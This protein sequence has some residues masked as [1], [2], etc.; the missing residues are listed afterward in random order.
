VARS[1][2]I[3]KFADL[4]AITVVCGACGQLSAQ[5]AEPASAKPAP[6]AGVAT[7]TDAAA[8]PVA[9]TPATPS[10]DCPCTAATA[11]PSL[12]GGDL[13]ERAK[14]TGNWGGARDTLLENGYNFNISNTNF[15]QGVASGGLDRGFQ[16]G[17]RVDYLFD[18]DGKKAG[19]WD[20][21]FVNLHGETLYGKSINA[22]TGAFM[23]PNIA[24]S[25]PVPDE[26][27]TALTGV[28]FTQ[29]F[30]E[31]FAV[32]FGK[33]NTLD[34]FN[35]PFTGGARGTDGFMAGGILFPVVMARTIPYSTFGA[36]GVVLSEKEPIF[37]VMVLDTNN[38]PTTSG[39]NT[40]FNNGASVE[41]MATLPTK[42]MDLPGHY[43]IAGTYSSGSYAALD[44]LPYF[45]AARLKGQYPTLP[46]ERGSWSLVGLFDQ[47]LYVDEQTKRSWGAFGNIGIADGNPNPVRWSGAIGLGGSS[48]WQARPQDSWG[49]G[50]YYIG[51]S[52]EIKNFA[53]RFVQPRDEHG[54][55]AFYNF[56]VAPWFH[57]SPS[58]QVITPLRGRVESSV[59]YGLRAK[60]DF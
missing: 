22:Q 58:L 51:I 18:V 11:I 54:V 29:A 42:V 38:T 21:F 48:M 8:T 5:T 25:V 28:K 9:T 46:K 19:L 23:P 24:M 49:I 55:E 53:P 12:F 33:I 32:F 40:F 44:D 34:L 16:F 45:L 36:G 14:L 41:V 3:K 20:G 60:M 1:H 56:A 6:T 13:H 35:Q 39:F 17:G 43:S 47:A 15:Y 4:L 52:D 26:N 30:S 57:L 27:I 2:V 7:V 10:T 59:N 37:S 31:N 50:Y